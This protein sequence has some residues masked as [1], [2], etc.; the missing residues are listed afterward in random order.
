MREID[1]RWT[2]IGREITSLS[3]PL[4]RSDVD[5]TQLALVWVPVG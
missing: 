4:E 3:V 1:E 5:V 2:T